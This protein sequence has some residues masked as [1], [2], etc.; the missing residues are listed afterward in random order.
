MRNV[1]ERRL[2]R[3][4]AVFCALLFA[5][6]SFSFVAVYQAPL[7][8]VFYDEVATG[9]LEFNA[10]LVGGIASLTLTLIALWLNRLAKFRR[11]WTAMAY[12]PSALLLAF[13]TDIDRSLYTGGSFSLMWV[14]I[15]AV[16]I[17]IYCFVAFVLRKMLFDLIQHLL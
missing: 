14:I 17:I 10:Y 15:F 12:L 11:E 2:Q 8:E 3:V 9:K 7:L 16:G 5:L 1:E 6:F 4:V 13:V